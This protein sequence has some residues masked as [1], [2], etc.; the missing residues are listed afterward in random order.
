MVATSAL[1]PAVA[2]LGSATLQMGKGSV[3]DGEVVISYRNPLE[4]HGKSTPN[5]F[6]EKPVIATADKG[7]RG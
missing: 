3:D 5:S 2:R 4:R 1:A 6:S 7:R